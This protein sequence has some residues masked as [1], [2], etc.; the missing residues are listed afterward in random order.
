MEGRSEGERM[1]SID[2]GKRGREKKIKEGK[3]K[4][5][6]STSQR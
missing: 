4:K 6:P 1:G 2:E 3:G 5:K